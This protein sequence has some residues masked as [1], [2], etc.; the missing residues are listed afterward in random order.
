MIYGCTVSVS[1]WYIP[2]IRLLAVETKG[3]GYMS[4]GTQAGHDERALTLESEY[5]PSG[6][7][8]VC[9]DS[10][11]Q[12]KFSTAI[13]VGKDGAVTLNVTA[14]E[15]MHSYGWPETKVLIPL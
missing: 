14:A 8:C 5:R 3:S 2:A 12:L 10:N 1:V 4:T 7:R 15:P 6:T 11:A 9:L 13:R